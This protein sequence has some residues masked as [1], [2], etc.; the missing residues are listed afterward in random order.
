MPSTRDPRSGA[1]PRAG[2][3]RSNLVARPRATG[4][5]SSRSWSGSRPPAGG[6]ERRRGQPTQPGVVWRVS[7]E[8]RQVEAVVRGRLSLGLDPEP[9][10][11]EH[12]PAH[13]MV[14]RGEVAHPGDDDGTCGADPLVHGVGVVPAGPVAQPGERVTPDV[15]VVWA[16]GP[17]R[18]T[19]RYRRS[20]SGA[21]AAR[22]GSPR[23]SVNHRARRQRA[24]SAARGSAAAQSDAARSPPGGDVAAAAGGSGP[25]GSAISWIASSS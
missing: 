4:P 2:R 23:R 24:E 8:E 6:L 3:T 25:R 10:T 20:R 12:L 16:P 9:P 13:L 14:D 19:A 11:A 18:R 1:V 7:V 5:R 21:G 17:A 22:G 15:G